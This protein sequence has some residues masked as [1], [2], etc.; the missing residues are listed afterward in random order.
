MKFITGVI[1]LIVLTVQAIGQNI[2]PYEI[3]SEMIK[4]ALAVDEMYV[5][6][7]KNERIDDEVIMEIYKMKLQYDPFKL[8]SIKVDDP[9]RQP[10]LLFIDGWN[11][12]KAFIYPGGFPW[13]NI[14]LDPMGS[15]MR[16]NQHH[17][18]FESGFRYAIGILDH[19]F[20]KYGNDVRDMSS[21][22]GSKVVN[23]VD[24]YLV[25]LENNYFK[26][27]RYTV[28]EGEDVLDIADKLKISEYKILEYNDDV[29]DFDDVEA[30]QEIMISNDY[31][32]RTLIAIDK[33]RMIPIQVKV[34][35]EIGLFEQ[36]DFRN[37]KLYPGFAEEEFT[38]DYEG[39]GF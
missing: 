36:L 13:L 4:T 17:T 10:E 18:L 3:T 8:Y 21:Y 20:R 32:M 16:R 5:E 31:S 29:D 38:T 37:V 6:M 26:K 33:K 24:C 27:V 39:Y 2:D 22:K 35:D 7:E 1:F 11:S 15:I 9:D 30:G 12:N 14:S 25:E 19:L 34:Y 23:K 28:K